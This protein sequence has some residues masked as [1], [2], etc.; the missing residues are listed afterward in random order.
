MKFVSARLL[1]I[2]FI[3]VDFLGL[4]CFQAE[5]RRLRLGKQAKPALIARMS[6]G[7]KHGFY[8]YSSCV[9]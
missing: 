5:T 8:A 9:L 7:Q 3:I 4:G 1:D 2:D 6:F